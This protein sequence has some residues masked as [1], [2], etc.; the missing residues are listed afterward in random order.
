M[1]NDTLE[2]V[3][4]TFQKVDQW[5]CD[6]V[7]VHETFF[8]NFK[9]FLGAVLIVS[10]KSSKRKC[11]LSSYVS[12][13][14]YEILNILEVLPMK[15]IRKF[16]NKKSDSQNLEITVWEIVTGPNQCK[17]NHLMNSILSTYIVALL[18]IIRQNN[19]YHLQK[20]FFGIC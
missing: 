16:M 10:N 5:K 17:T 7:Y 6:K 9:N 2:I 15:L 1:L 20:S 3:I 11:S 19:E 18:T 14:E 4:A 12:I 13:S 8:K